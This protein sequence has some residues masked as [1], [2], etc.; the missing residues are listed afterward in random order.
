MHQ[1]IG[2]KKAKQ[3]KTP[4]VTPAISY[5]YAAATS[6]LHVYIYNYYN[7]CLHVCLYKHCIKYLCNSN[8]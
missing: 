1:D 7:L 2:H 3:R 5:A 6:S 4:A 8:D